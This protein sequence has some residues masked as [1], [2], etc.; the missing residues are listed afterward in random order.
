MAVHAP[1]RQSL[2]GIFRRARRARALPSLAPFGSGRRRAAA[3]LSMT[4]M[5]DVMVVCVVFLL[6]TFSSSSECACRRDLSKIPP[7]A[8]VREIVDAPLIFVTAEGIFVDGAP[9]ERRDEIAAARPTRLDKTFAIL[10]AEHAVAKQASPDRAAPTHVT[11]AIE[12]DVPVGVVKSV[13]RTAASSG[14]SDVDFM[15]N[16]ASRRD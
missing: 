8:N 12:G 13:T 3:G 10:E 14:Y 5:I 11:L 6:L 16:A 2:E 4:S 15:V 9:A 1:G 7:A